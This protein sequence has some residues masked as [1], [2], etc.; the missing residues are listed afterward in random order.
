MSKKSSHSRREFMEGVLAAG[1]AF[2][3]AKLVRGEENKYPLGDFGIPLV[4]QIITGPD[5][6]CFWAGFS[7][8]NNQVAFVTG[9]SDRQSLYVSTPGKLGSFDLL[10]EPPSDSCVIRALAWSP[11]GQEIAFLVE[12]SDGQASLESAKFSIYIVNVVSH[13]VHE[14][15]SI[16]E[17]IGKAVGT[18]TNTIFRNNLAWYGNSS[19]CVAADTGGVLKFDAL[20]GKSDILVAPQNGSFISSIALTRSGELRFVRK[21]KIEISKDYEIVVSG[22]GQDGTFHDYVNLNQQLGQIFNARL[23]QDGEF[24]FVEKHGVPPKSLLAFLPVTYLIDKIESQNVIGEVP[25]VVFHQNDMY[26]Y[27]PLAVQND[28]ELV[29][30]EAFSPVADGDTSMRN[31]I[32][33]IVKMPILPQKQYRTG[34]V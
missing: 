3:F 24:V 4:T 29:L 8:V 28:Q 17:N 21:K 34:E 12:A 30:I 16:K 25:A 19:L 32:T 33:K 7:P 22:L 20:T 5:D 15:I 27:L 31:T 26:I 2:A 18:E 1:T 13:A 23:S 6:K 11:N 14:P 9:I 10:W